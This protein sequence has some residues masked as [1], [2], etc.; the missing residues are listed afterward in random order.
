MGSTVRFALGIGIASAAIVAILAILGT[1]APDREGRMAASGLPPQTG[2][3]DP[4]EGRR[5]FAS[6][7]VA[8]H[9]TDLRGTDQGP[10]LLHPYYRPQHHS[11][12]AFYRAVKNGVQAH[13][14]EFGDMPPVPAVDA[15][16]TRDIIAYIRREQ[17]EAGLIDK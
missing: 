8:C 12:L 16:Q 9:G 7:C 10:P 4:A 1:L 6:H 11:D 13:H 5:I 15:E 3:G 14:W 2:T 17:R